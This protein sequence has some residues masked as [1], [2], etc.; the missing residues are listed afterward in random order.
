MKSVAIVVLVM[1]SAVG[2][3]Q[4]EQRYNVAGMVIKVEPEHREFVVSC[5][6]VPGYMDAMVMS[7]TVRDVHELDGLSAGASVEFTLIVDHDNSFAEKV[8]VLAYESLERDPSTAKRLGDLDKILDPSSAAVELQCGQTIPDFSLIDQ[9]RHR[10]TLSQFT[11]KVVALTFIYTRCPL[12]NYCFRL[13]N[14]F[15]RLQTRFAN[16]MGRDL[17]LL[18]ISFDPVHD[19][20]DVLAKYGAVWRAD[21]RGWRLLTGPPEQVQR[22]CRMFGMDSWPEEGLLTHSLHTAVIDRNGKLAANIEGN[23]F[24]A[25]ELGDLVQSV[26]DRA[27]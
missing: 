19:Q 22:I 3:A 17:V 10:V 21:S 23:Q 20:P 16:R 12:P 8:H 5:R 13:S 25:E 26:M 27:P 6:A 4:A 2:C 14:N 7:F 24:T 11:G 9:N 1:T 15:G 18:S